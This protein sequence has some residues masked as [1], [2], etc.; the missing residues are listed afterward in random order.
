MGL[1][2][3]QFVV[4]E[5]IAIER[6]ISMF[7]V[8]AAVKFVRTAARGELDLDGAFSVAFSAGSRSGNADL[9]DGVGLGLTQGEETIGTF[10]KMVLNVK[11]VEG[12]VQHALGQSVDG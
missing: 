11:P 5:K 10:Q 3:Q 4:P 7:L 2:R 6:F 8:D 9:R 12:N 1:G